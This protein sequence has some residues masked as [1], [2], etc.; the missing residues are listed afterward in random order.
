LK[1][2][3]SFSFFEGYGES[4]LC[5]SLVGVSATTTRYDT[6]FSHRLAGVFYIIFACRGCTFLSVS[7]ERYPKNA[8]RRWKGLN[9]CARAQ[10]ASHPSPSLTSPILSVKGRGH[11][12][13]VG[14]CVGVLSFDALHGGNETV[15]H[16]LVGVR[17]NRSLRILQ[18]QNA[19]ALGL[20]SER[21]RGR[22]KRG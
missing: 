16:N 18:K 5:F 21:R 19:R 4:G 14:W 8:T 6:L 15:I 1:G 12:R 17:E 10:I 20:E 13:A 11:R 22:M 9:L 3:R 7:T 2:S